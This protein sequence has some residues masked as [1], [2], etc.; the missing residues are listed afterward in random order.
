MGELSSKNIKNQTNSRR[1]D[2]TCLNS[3]LRADTLLFDVEVWDRSP[4]KLPPREYTFNLIFGRCFY[5]LGGIHYSISP[6]CLVL[7]LFQKDACRAG[8][9][10]AI[11][12]PRNPLFPNSGRFCCLE[13]VVPSFQ[14]MKLQISINGWKDMPTEPKNQT[15]STQC[16]TRTPTGGSASWP[17]PSVALSLFPTAPTP[18]ESPLWFEN[19]GNL[20]PSPSP[21][22]NT[23]HVCSLLPALLAGGHPV[24]VS[25]LPW[26]VRPGAMH[27][28]YERE[29]GS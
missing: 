22:L 17:W 8:L 19:T 23:G 5:H 27:W 10:V 15:V 12:V 25:C 14:N 6:F 9:S 11:Q 28:E 2:K 16:P 20:Q 3:Q 13:T 7:F 29:Q 18:K 1:R 4:R 21:G 24:N 26:G